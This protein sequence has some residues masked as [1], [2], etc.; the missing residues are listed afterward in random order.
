MSDDTPVPE[1]MAAYNNAAA[2]GAPS[3]RLSSRP[4]PEVRRWF[5][6]ADTGGISPWWHHIGARLALADR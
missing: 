5:A 1:S 4:E 2:G 6:E 3:F